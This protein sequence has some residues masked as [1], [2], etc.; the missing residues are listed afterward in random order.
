MITWSGPDAVRRKLSLGPTP[1][2]DEVDRRSREPEQRRDAQESPD[3]DFA[4]QAC[5]DARALRPL[6]RAI[7]M[8]L[9]KWYDVDADPAAAMK[10]KSIA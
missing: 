6:L 7:V 8:A 5:F 4:G 3:V 1:L 2:T 9:T 10:L